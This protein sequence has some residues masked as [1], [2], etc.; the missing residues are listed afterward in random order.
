MNAHLSTIRPAQP[1]QMLA[2]APRPP[3]ETA[4][5]ESEL[6]A[7][8]K[9]A[10]IGEFNFV[11]GLWVAIFAGVMSACMA[12]AFTAAEPIAAVAIKRGAPPVLQDIPM[13]VVVLLG[14]FTTNFIW[15]L[16]LNIKKRVSEIVRIDERYV[17]R[18]Q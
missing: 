4:K 13:L 11:K 10:T 9:T 16:Y 3:A 2:P 17:Q 5:E 15:C 12:F 8:E 6:R 14:G 18:Y 1:S 7:E